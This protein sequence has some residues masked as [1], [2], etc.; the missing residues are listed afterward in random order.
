MLPFR[1]KHGGDGCGVGRWSAENARP[2]A[3][4]IRRKKVDVE[5]EIGGWG[6]C[7]CWNTCMRCGYLG[8]VFCCCGVAEFNVDRGGED[9]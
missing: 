9:T 2:S 4:S 5:V 8:G 7:G 1:R 3:A 6:E